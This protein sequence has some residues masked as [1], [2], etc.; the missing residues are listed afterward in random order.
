MYSQFRFAEILVPEHKHGMA[1]LGNILY[2]LD[3]QEQIMKIFIGYDPFKKGQEPQK[4]LTGEEALMCFKK[5]LG[6]EECV[7]NLNL[8]DILYAVSYA[9]GLSYDTLREK[10]RIR[11]V[12]FARFLVMVTAH[13]ELLYSLALAGSLF[14]KDHATVLHAKKEVEKEDKYLKEYQVT[15]KN[16]FYKKLEEIRAEKLASKQEPTK[17]IA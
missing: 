1:N 2:K 11:E 4:I 17:Q 8:S 3:K 6:Y 9:S 13:K 16:S 10:T 7:N 14:G 12:V 5:M 15:M